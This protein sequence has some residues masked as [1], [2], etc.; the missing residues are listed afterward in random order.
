MGGQVGSSSN[1]A[2]AQCHGGELHDAEVAYALDRSRRDMNPTDSALADV[3]RS[4]CLTTAEK[5]QIIRTLIHEGR[6]S[7]I[8]FFAHA[9]WRN[10]VGVDRDGVNADLQVIADAL[11]GAFE[12]KAIDAG[13]LAKAVGLF[14]ADG[15]NVRQ[16]ESAQ[17]FLS[18]LQ[19]STKSQSAAKALADELWKQAGHGGSDRAAAAIYYLSDP[20]LAAR[21]L[22]DAANRADA[23]KALSKFSE[24]ASATL[25]QIFAG[26]DNPKTALQIAAQMKADGL[27]DASAII[28][29]AVID[30]V[31][32]FKR[33]V[34]DDVKKLAEHGAELAFAVRNCRGVMTTQQLDVAI[35][36][37]RS[38]R[39]D[40]WKQQENRLRDQIGKDGK[41][42]AEQ[43]AAL[44]QHR[45]PGV[46]SALQAILGDPAADMAI[47]TAIQMHPELVGPQHVEGLI[48]LFT[49][50]KV[51]DAGRKYL[52][53]MASAYLRENVLKQMEHVNLRDG[54]SVARAKEAIETLR[55][56]TF[57]RLAG[58]TEKQLGAAVNALQTAV[59][60]SGT[61][62]AQAKQAMAEFETTLRSPALLRAFDAKSLPG[63][64]M[65]T[66]GLVFAGAGVINS[67]NGVANKSSLPTDLKL[68]LDSAGFLHKTSEVLVGLRWVSE[69]SSVAKFA[70]WKAAGRATASDLIG[71]AGALLDVAVAVDAFSDEDY[72]SGAFSLLSAAGGVVSTLPA[73]GVGGAWL[74][75]VGIAL[76]VCATFGKALYT[77]EKANHK[78]DG[79]VANFLKQAGFKDTAVARLSDRSGDHGASQVVILAKYAEL[80]GMTPEALKNWVNSLSD[81][82]LEKLS[83][84]LMRAVVDCDGNP[85]RFTDRKYKGGPDETRVEEFPGGHDGKAVTAFAVP[86]VNKVVVFE[87]R[88]NGER[89]PDRDK[90]PLPPPR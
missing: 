90:V 43:L 3:L 51:A 26:G 42:L 38:Q 28:E 37:W 20:Q 77:A 56:S 48:N 23:A 4:P 86:L 41:V 15:G 52:N 81:H 50:F 72:G 73:I 7:Q 54:G 83:H 18:L 58:V 24:A 25:R 82:Q 13:D 80:K 36:Q 85:D 30:G 64:M 40:A 69:E 62:A 84:A 46:D 31:Q 68:V 45:S 11:Q 29:K 19:H 59:D 2:A 78:Y 87:S 9:G 65:R 74:G 60:Q 49:S 66:V 27:A 14:A 16:F 35:S 6:E 79:V 8:V 12:R 21:H 34:A 71:A 75:P 63:I 39:S 10:H 17:Q 44:G 1:Q 76:S 55:G 5:D 33:K 67:Y 22:G 47:T 70:T 89:V 57:A 53:E 61:T 32:Q 88:L